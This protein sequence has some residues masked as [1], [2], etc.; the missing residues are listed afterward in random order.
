MSFEKDLKWALFLDEYGG[1]LT[2]KQRKVFDM[3]YNEDCSLAEISGQTGTSRQG[4]LDAL[5][6]A[7]TKMKDCEV[8][9][10]LVQKRLEESGGV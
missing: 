10:G 5:R 7:E 6:R 8:K 1:F 9:L 2:E 3:Y 4:A